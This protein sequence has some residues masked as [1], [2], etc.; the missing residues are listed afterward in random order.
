[1]AFLALVGLALATASSIAQQTNVFISPQGT[2]TGGTASGNQINVSFGGGTWQNWFINDPGITNYSITFDTANP[3]PSGDVLGSVLQEQDWNGTSAGTLATFAC[4]DN[5]FWGGATIDITKFKTLEMDFKY[6]TN[7]TILPTNRAQ[8]SIMVDNTRVSSVGVTLTNLAN[9]GAT[10][11][12]FDGLWHHLSIAIPSTISGVTAS[13]GPGFTIFNPV[14]TAG[15]FRYWV[16][17]LEF[18]ARTNPPPP[19][20]ISIDKTTPGLRQFADAV[21]SYNR[22]SIRTDTTAAG[23]KNIDWVGHPGAKYSWTI[24]EWPGPGH[25]NFQGALTLT[26]DPAESMNYSD[27]DWSSSNVLWISFSSLAD[28]SVAATV[29][30]KTNQPAGNSQFGGSGVGTGMLGTNRIVVPNAIG[31][32]SVSFADNTHLTLSAPG[33]ISTNVVLDAGFGDPTSYTNISAALYTTM[34][35]DANAGQ[36]ATLTHFDITGVAVP[37]HE[38]LT[39]GTLDTPFLRLDSQGYFGN[40]APPN[41]VFVTSADKYWLH[42][43]LP[44]SGYGLVE[45]PTL[46]TPYWSDFAPGNVLLNGP[47]R[48]LLVPAAAL[49]SSSQSYFAVEK[50]V[51]TQLQVLLSGESPAPNTPSGKTGT[52]DPVS[53]AA[54]STTDVTVRAVDNLWNLVSSTDT[55]HLTTTDTGAA[56]PADL[57][58]V[59]GVAAFTSTAGNNLIFSQQGSF[60]VTATNMSRV[61]PAATS[62]SVT[63]GP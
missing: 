58:M 42:W 57:A 56:V 41:Q 22:Q 38:D 4:V 47:S 23:S 28:G 19:P 16:A 49:P 30:C 51:F 24:S 2:E 33:G 46:T 1:M 40:L 13:K 59:G 26:S 43:T 20:T 18:I 10:A 6:D 45:K 25:A 39:D 50:R 7:S 53:M 55:I 9:S 52:P 8:V 27:P 35:G 21:P 11:P 32:W 60:T 14:G 12:D 62:S 15:T 34:S 63:V 61:M 17:N 44:D 36:F 48:W 29:R 54:G 37:V 5:N 31:T 3:P